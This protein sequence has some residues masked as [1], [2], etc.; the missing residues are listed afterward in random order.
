MEN[1]HFNIDG[2]MEITSE[3]FGV[4]KRLPRGITGSYDQLYSC[5]LNRY[6]TEG[7]ARLCLRDLVRQQR[8]ADTDLAYYELRRSVS[9]LTSCS[10]DVSS[11]EGFVKTMAARP[12]LIK[13]LTEEL[14]YALERIENLD[15]TG[16]METLFA[17]KDEETQEP[18]VDE[19][20][21]G[22]LLPYY[23]GWRL[24]GV[25]GT[26]LEE[27]TKYLLAQLDKLA[28]PDWLR[29]E[30]LKEMNAELKRER[31]AL[32]AE[33]TEG[34]YNAFGC[35]TRKLNFPI[36]NKALWAVKSDSAS[37]VAQAVNFLLDCPELSGH[38]FFDFDDDV[39][40]MRKLA[41]DPE[42]V[43]TTVRMMESSCKD[44]FFWEARKKC[45]K[46]KQRLFLYWMMGVLA[47]EVPLVKARWMTQKITEALEDTSSGSDD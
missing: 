46:E 6:P 45:N 38:C 42:F 34:M 24:A 23:K 16:L 39:G 44:P 47:A 28:L 2:P 30:L 31:E 14:L 15:V 7:A 43:S 10:A 25:Q 21:R 20:T 4:Y 11:G 22:R 35:V 33:M 27:R 9:Y 12:E 36:L 8:Y 5:W 19:E 29:E 13:E 1:L 3:D 17:L 37:G 41:G 26:L 40:I 18:L 32:P